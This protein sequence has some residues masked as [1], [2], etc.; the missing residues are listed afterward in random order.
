VTALAK[1]ELIL[2]I[3]AGLDND[4]AG[5]AELELIQKKLREKSSIPVSESP[6]S[7]ARTLADHGVRLRHPEI[8]EADLRWRQTR[9]IEL[10]APE[11]LTFPT[12]E[13][14]AAWMDKLSALEPRPELRTLV[15]QVKTELALVASSKQVSVYQRDIASEVAEWLAVWLQNPP[16]FADW[17]LLRRQSPDFS[18]RFK[19]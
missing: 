5:A 3:W 6:A 2:E 12:I 14:A 17:L 18:T 13:T 15:L 11:E 9:E 16:I 7:I 4:S 19:T 8:L 10:F 1:D